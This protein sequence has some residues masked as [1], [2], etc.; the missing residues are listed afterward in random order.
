MDAGRRDRRRHHERCSMK[1]EARHGK[2]GRHV[3]TLRRDDGGAAWTDELVPTKGSDRRRFIES[4]TEKLPELDGKW[5]E[6]QLLELGDRPAPADDDEQDDGRAEIPEDPPEICAEA[7]AMLG[8]GDLMDEVRA[9]IGACG[10]ACDLDPAMIVYLAM[11]SRLLEDPVSMFAQGPSSTGKTFIGRVV[12]SMMPPE[13]VIDVQDITTQVLFYMEDQLRHRI[14]LQGEWC[15]SDEQSENGIR[16]QALRQ[17]ISDKRI[18]KLYTNTESGKPAA[19]KA[20]T[21][22]PVAAYATSTLPM[23]KIFEEDE[24]R[25]LFIHTDETEDATRRVLERQAAIAAGVGRA[26]EAVIERIQELHRAAQ[27]EIRRQAAPL[28]VPFAPQ[29]EKR[30]PVD[31]PR[32]RRDFPKLLGLIK[33]C[34]LLHH[35]QRTRDAEGRILAQLEDY[36]HVH[37]LLAPYMVK[38]GPTPA[39]QRKYEQLKKELGL[40]ETF[41]RINVEEIL[42][43]KKSAAS[44]L[45][46]DLRDARLLEDVSDLPYTYRLRDAA[47]MRVSLLPDPAEV[48]SDS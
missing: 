31:Q 16:T 24:N 43:L 13:D 10:L 19:E 47:G 32:R 8:S 33:A 2:N 40:V 36:R 35:R 12:A 38:D 3:V 34:A 27:R 23:S 17:L 18:T 22:G 15:R 41:T 44:D 25:F 39:T 26:S 6:E 30:F 4:A 7:L 28:L 48:A 29:L 11:T 9:G 14:L 46:R 45:I 37:D 20:T 5:L 21:E 1:L 42:G